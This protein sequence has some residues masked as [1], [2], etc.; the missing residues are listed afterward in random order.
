MS[1]RGKRSRDCVD[2]IVYYETS[3]RQF[4]FDLLANGYLMHK[5]TVEW[6]TE[7]CDGMDNENGDDP[8]PDPSLRVLR[9]WLAYD[10]LPASNEV[11]RFT[12]L[13]DNGVAQTRSKRCPP[14]LHTDGSC[15][16]RAREAAER[17]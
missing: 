6:E 16:R 14:A 2:T 5:A 8:L 7:F 17:K 12:N 15:L 1:E 11:I 3:A 13:Y 9:Y 10:L 4:N